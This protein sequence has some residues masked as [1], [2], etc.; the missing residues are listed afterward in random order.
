MGSAGQC[1]LL[2][3]GRVRVNC[4]ESLGISP[5]K[6]QWHEAAVEGRRCNMG[7]EGTKG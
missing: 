2:E 4:K 5:V 6:A 7:R 1:R 3:G